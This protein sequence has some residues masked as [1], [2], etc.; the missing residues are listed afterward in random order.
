MCYLYSE[1]LPK[2]F[3]KKFSDLDFFTIFYLLKDKKFF[4]GQL[5][6]NFT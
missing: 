4:L 1:Y 5:L 6:R 3:S 2:K